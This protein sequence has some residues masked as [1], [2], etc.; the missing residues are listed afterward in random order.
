VSDP[1]DGPSPETPRTPP[2]AEPGA[3]IPRWLAWV[4]LLAL[5]A[6]GGWLTWRVLAFSPDTTVP[7]AA[8]ESR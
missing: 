4:V 1:S 5:L 8:A 2:F 7:P 6:T 3:G